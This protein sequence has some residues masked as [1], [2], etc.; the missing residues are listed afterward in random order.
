VAFPRKERAYE[1]YAWIFLFAVGLFFLIL[2]SVKL[3]QALSGQTAEGLP[4]SQLGPLS[5]AAADQIK[6]TIGDSGVFALILFFFV[7][8]TA[9]KSYRKGEK[10]SWYVFWSLPA[11]IVTSLVLTGFFDPPAWIILVLSLLGLLLPY[12]KFFPK[13]QPVTS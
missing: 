9:L 4:V 11:L 13:K 1:K 7:T 12:R 2:G 10:W 8:G 6:E 5:S 3:N